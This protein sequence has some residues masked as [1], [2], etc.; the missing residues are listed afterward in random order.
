MLP[1]SSPPTLTTLA[2]TCP[3]RRA[4]ASRLTFPSTCTSPLNLPAMRIWPV[5]T[6]L[7]S[8]VRSEDMYDS[9]MSWR[10]T[11]AGAGACAGRRAGSG[12]P[13]WSS[14]VPAHEPGPA[15]GQSRG[16]LTRVRFR[17]L[18]LSKAPWVVPVVIE[19][20]KVPAQPLWGQCL[21]LQTS[22]CQGRVQARRPASVVSVAPHT[23]RE[24]VAAL[25]LAIRYAVRQETGKRLDPKVIHLIAA[26][27][28]NF[29]KVA[30]L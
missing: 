11:W 7:P 21:C 19:R 26:A 8:M 23:R 27:R 17:H 2:F 18:Y 12:P 20:W 10:C 5:P 13:H 15:R 25:S 29:M 22:V 30:P 24:H 9:F 4:P 16:W 6:I 1:M 3:S 28:P 14:Q